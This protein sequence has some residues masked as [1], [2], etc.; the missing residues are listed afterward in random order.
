M[1][2]IGIVGWKNNGKTTLIEKLISHFAGLNLKVSSIKHAHHAFDIDH[3]GKDSYRHRT[4]GAHEV[5]VASKTRWALIHELREESEPELDALLAH[6]A[7]ADLVIVEGFKRHAHP[8]IEVILDQSAPQIYESEGQNIIAVASKNPVLD[9]RLPIL[10]LNKPEE[11]ARFILD[12]L[13]IESAG[14]AGE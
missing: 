6:L 11:V 4:A 7:P 14:D 12:Y 1:K 5:V 3:P 13:Q 2:V 8:K 10:P 9:T